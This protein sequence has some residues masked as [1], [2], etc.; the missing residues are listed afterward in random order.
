MKHCVVI[1]NKNHTDSVLSMSLP[2]CSL[3]NCPLFSSKAMQSVCNII[4][5]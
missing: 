1:V 4:K 2:F 5:V 3:Y